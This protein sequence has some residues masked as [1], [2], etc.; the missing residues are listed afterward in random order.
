MPK[1]AWDSLLSERDR[2]VLRESGY[3]SEGASNWDTRGYGADPA[4]VVI[5]M[6]RFIAGDDEP[7]VD[8]VKES[9][10]S[11]GEV[12]WTATRDHL[13]PFLTAVRDIGL[14]VYHMRIIPPSYDDPDDDALWFV[15]PMEPEPGEAVIEK[16]YPSAFY[17]TDLVSRLIR[18][19]VDTL[20]LIGN[21]TS[22]CVRATAIDAQQYGFKLIVPEDCVFDRIEASHRVG[23]LDLWMKYAEVAPRETVEAELRSRYGAGADPDADTDGSGV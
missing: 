8:A 10:I 6:Q 2:R 22:G 5:D 17:G 23:L 7:I 16:R 14:P 13:A 20:V 12:A 4:V 11:L 19:G 18:R 9:R 1:R 15:E 3:D 21:T